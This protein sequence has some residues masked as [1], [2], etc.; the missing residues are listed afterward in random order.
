MRTVVGERCV[1]LVGHDLNEIMKE[2]ACDLPRGYLMKLNED[3]LR[4]AGDD[5]EQVDPSFGPVNLS[6][7]DV[8]VAEWEGLEG[9]RCLGPPFR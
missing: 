3:E 1:H 8:E 4:R 7:I 2:V 5:Y 6:Q 9:K